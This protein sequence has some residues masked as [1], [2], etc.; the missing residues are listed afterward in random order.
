[1]IAR[2]MYLTGDRPRA[3]WTR[4]SDYRRYRFPDLGTVF[5]V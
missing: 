5:N 2:E 1:M 4:L 3:V